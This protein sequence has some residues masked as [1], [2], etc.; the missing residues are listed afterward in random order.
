MRAEYRKSTRRFVRPGATSACA[1][2]L[3]MGT[4]LMID[5]SDSGARL[6]FD[7]ADAAPDELILLLSH[8]G[9]LRRQCSFDGDSVR[10]SEP[11]DETVG[12]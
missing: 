8:D 6:K 12:K 4:C 3:A 7:V 9:E 11:V 1:D 10:R 5:P 2:G